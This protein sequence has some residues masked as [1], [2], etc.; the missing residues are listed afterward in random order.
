MRANVAAERLRRQRQIANEVHNRSL[1]ERG[2]QEQRAR[3]QMLGFEQTHSPRWIRNIINDLPDRSFI[4][5]PGAE[6]P[7]A[8]AGVGWGADGRTL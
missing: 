8:T 3:Q 6:E 7:D 1:A 4:H 2:Q 5:G